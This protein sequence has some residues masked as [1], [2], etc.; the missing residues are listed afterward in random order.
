MDQGS[1]LHLNHPIE[2][3]KD[4]LAEHYDAIF[5]GTGAPKGRELDLPGR[6]DTDQ[7]FVGIAWLESVAFEHIESVGERVLIIGGGNTAMDC[8]R[9]SLRLGGKEVKVLYRGTRDRMK[10]SDWELEPA[11]EEDVEL[12]LN[13]SPEEY[14]V[15]E[16]KL[17]G[18]KFSVLE[19]HKDKNGK[20]KSTKKDEVIIPCDTVILAIGQENSFPWVLSLI[21]I[22][23]PTR[24]Y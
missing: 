5:V 11:L 8:C 14:I 16:G 12:I 7:I 15:E 17:V 22:S 10:S 19:W 18:M 23:E 6:Y 13:H 4:L 9:T 3:M 2:S 21:H 24:P 20:L 1:K